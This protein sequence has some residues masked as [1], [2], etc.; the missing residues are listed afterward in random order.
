MEKNEKMVG[1]AGFHPTL[2]QLI[3]I[4]KLTLFLLFFTISQIFAVSTYSQATRLSLDLKNAAVK[5]VLLEI[6][7]NSEFYFLYSNKLIDAE[8]KVNVN[9]KNKRVDN[10]LDE[11]FEGENVVYAIND[12][13]IILSPEGMEINNPAVGSQQAKK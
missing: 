6:E 4:M 7:N 2:T 5:D 8:R 1:S 3:R 12:R 11:I 9:V 13:Q 10:I